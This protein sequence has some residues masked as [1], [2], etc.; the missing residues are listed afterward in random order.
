M[1]SDSMLNTFRDVLQA[2]K[3]EN[4]ILNDGISMFEQM[5]VLNNA[6]GATL[7]ALAD[8]HLADVKKLKQE[9]EAELKAHIAEIE[10]RKQGQ[11]LENKR[12]HA[13]LEKWKRKHASE[14]E[15]VNKQHQAE[16]RKM[17]RERM[18]EKGERASNAAMVALFKEEIAKV[19]ETFDEDQRQKVG[20]YREIQGYATREQ[21]LLREVESRANGQRVALLALLDYRSNNLDDVHTQQIEGSSKLVDSCAK[22]QELAQ[23]YISHSEK[24]AEEM[25]RNWATLKNMDKV[26][27]CE[28]IRKLIEIATAGGI[29]LGLTREELFED[30]AKMPS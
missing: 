14:L 15:L 1:A 18:T 11:G 30:E 24:R 7:E 3:E 17:K 16:I 23:K 6:R 21:Q 4:Q 25:E 22:D 28:R 29:Q 27:H 12:Y 5:K 26:A 19:R 9:H 10:K 8:A 20:M 13:E 2:Q